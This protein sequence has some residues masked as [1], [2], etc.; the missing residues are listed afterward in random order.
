MDPEVD[1]GPG[2]R[3]EDVGLGAAFY[4]GHGRSGADQRYSRLLHLQDQKD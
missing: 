2:V 1:D 4:H 3:G